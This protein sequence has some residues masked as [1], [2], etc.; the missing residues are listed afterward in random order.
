MLVFPFDEAMKV[1]HL[2]SCEACTVFDDY[3]CTQ[4]RHFLGKIIECTIASD[5]VNE[6]DFYLF[7]LGMHWYVRI[8]VW[9]ARITIQP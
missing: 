6:G 3:D 4:L 5:D 7:P 9:S 8:G 2:I 1:P